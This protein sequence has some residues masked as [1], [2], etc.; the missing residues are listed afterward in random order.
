MVEDVYF[1]LLTN[2]IGGDDYDPDGIDRKVR[3]YDVVME[4]DFFGFHLRFL[5]NYWR[6]FAR[7]TSHLT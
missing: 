3:N 5:E 2:N 1:V 7:A 6:L 4:D